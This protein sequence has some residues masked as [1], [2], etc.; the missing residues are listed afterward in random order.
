MEDRD[1][2]PRFWPTV[3]FTVLFAIAIIAVVCSIAA[4]IPN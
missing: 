3:I 2:E 4:L 1:R